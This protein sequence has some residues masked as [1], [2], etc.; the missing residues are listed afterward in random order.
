MNCVKPC[1]ISRTSLLL[2]W[3]SKSLIGNTL[4]FKII[5]PNQGSGAQHFAEARVSIGS[6]AIAKGSCWRRGQYTSSSELVRSLQGNAGLGGR[7]CPVSY[8]H[9]SAPGGVAAPSSN[10]CPCREAYSNA[11]CQKMVTEIPPISVWNLKDSW[12][13]C[14]Q[15]KSAF[16]HIRNACE[17]LTVLSE[18]LC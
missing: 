7:P 13:I 18:R 4:E 11:A 17:I 15:Q 1:R 10:P 6:A 9:Q 8:M 16:C 5:P 2:Q 12:I 3:W 14:F